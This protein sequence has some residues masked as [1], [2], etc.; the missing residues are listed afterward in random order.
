M[1][2][3][4]DTRCLVSDLRGFRVIFFF[5]LLGSGLF[6]CRLLAWIFWIFIMLHDTGLIMREMDVF[7]LCPKS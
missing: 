7:V 3:V 1:V 4:E 5:D 6:A 2:G